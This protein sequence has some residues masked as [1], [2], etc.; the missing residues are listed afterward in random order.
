MLFEQRRE[1]LLQLPG[2]QT[3]SRHCSGEFVLRGG[4]GQESDKLSPPQP[5]NTQAS[6]QFSPLILRDSHKSLSATYEVALV[7][8][9]GE[10][11][12]KPCGTYKNSLIK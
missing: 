8:A 9:T 11:T 3:Y 4:S 1:L 5:S 6:S 12:S 10:E 2:E 7:Q